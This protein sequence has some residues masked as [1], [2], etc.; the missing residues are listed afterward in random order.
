M[1]RSLWL[2][3]SEAGGQREGTGGGCHWSLV[4]QSDR[5]TSFFQ[6]IPPK[7]LLAI[8]L[9]STLEKRVELFL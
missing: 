4:C 9:M 7:P 3:Q 6:L 5:M 8:D 1:N 2:G